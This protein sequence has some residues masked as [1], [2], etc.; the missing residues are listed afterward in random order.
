MPIIQAQQYLTNS[1]QWN[2]N[3]ATYGNHAAGNTNGGHGV[4]KGNP[5]RVFVSVYSPAAIT[6]GPQ[7]QTNYALESACFAVT[8]SGSPPLYYQW[9]F[10]G[11]NLPG[12]T[13]STLPLTNLSTNQA[14]SYQVIVTNNYGSVTSLVATLTV[15][16]PRPQILANSLARANGQFGFTMQSDIGCHFEIQASTNLA[17]WTSLTT[18]TNVSGTIAVHRHVHEHQMAILPGAPIAIATTIQF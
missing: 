14:G 10:N 8:A 6:Q 18:L 17:D 3:T 2:L 12:A 1:N 16:P 13:A 4:V 9:Q 15:L 11:T 7:S 5:Q